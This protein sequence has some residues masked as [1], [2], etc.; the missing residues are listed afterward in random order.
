MPTGDELLFFNA[1]PGWLPL[2]E[3]LRGQ[4]VLVRHFDKPGI[5]DYL[6]IT[7]GS[8]EEMDALLAALDRI[9][10]EKGE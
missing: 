6:R 1:H 10:N 3:A 4:G 7:I 8:K 9:P 5:R 2:Y